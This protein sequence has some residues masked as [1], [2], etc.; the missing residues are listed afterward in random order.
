MSNDFPKEFLW[1]SATAS[2]Q[3]EGAAN[4]DGKGKSIWDTF[5]HTP[6]KIK[7]N[8]NGDIA[9]D[10]YHRYKE[11]ISLMNDAKFN[12][13]R[14]SISWPRIIPEGTG[15]INQKG[16]DFYSKV[17]D[18]CLKYNIKP[19]ITLYHWDLPQK[20]QDTGG[21]ANRDI[22]KIFSDYSEIIAKK[23][24]DRCKDFIT[25]NEPAVFSIHG[26]TDGYMAPGYKN[27]EK[28]LAAVHHINLS[29]GESFQ[30]I[31]SI[32]TKINV[33]CTLN[34]APCI[35][36]TDDKKDKVAT[37]IFD[38]HWNRSYA[39]PMYLG[40]YPDLL[41]DDLSKYIKQDDMKI[42]YQK[43]D[44]IGLNH[45]QHIRVKADENHLL[46]AR[47]AF[48]DELPFGLNNDAKLTFM[49]WEIV[50]D[51]Y[52][53][54]IMDLKNNYGDPDIYLTE[55]G[56]AYPDKIDKNGEVQD[57]DRIDYFQKYLGAVKKAIDHGAKVKSYFAWTFMDNFEWAL[58]FEKRFGIVHVDFKTLKRTP[59]KSY[60]FFQKLIK[61]NSIPT[62]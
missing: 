30:A 45:Y 19:F 62:N 1:G 11:D 4:K 34:M 27:K 18:E 47:G 52:Y 48:N 3:I 12:S 15:S 46:K 61:N 36:A 43:N 5:T 23:F 21:W 38:T 9:V 55:N 37:K 35:P 28:Y 40:K 26:Y 51:A 17:I 53:D 39:N 54:Q 14:F 6:G 33:G 16:I 29:H 42:I 25:F 24:G 31:K 41:I 2:Y 50:P 8:E 44:F 7:N 59:K 32:S 22:T 49:G 13:Y 58:G 56:C 10:H 57:L 20:L 60:Y